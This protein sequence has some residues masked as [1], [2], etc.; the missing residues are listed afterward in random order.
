MKLAAL[1]DSAEKA[2]KLCGHRWPES[3]N[4]SI[5]LQHLG[6]DSVNQVSLWNCVAGN[7]FYFHHQIFLSALCQG[8]QQNL[9]LFCH[10]GFAIQFT[11]D[12]VEIVLLGES[13]N[14][15]NW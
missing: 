9:S 5:K 4:K 10:L 6:S 1:F 15:V 8:S 14:A 2:M 3:P 12:D 11:Y 7:R 13:F